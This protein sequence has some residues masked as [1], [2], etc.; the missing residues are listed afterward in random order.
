MDDHLRQ[1]VSPWVAEPDPILRAALGKLC[2]EAGELIAAASRCLIQ[3]LD[4]VEPETQRPNL[5]W[6]ENEV[7]D[8]TAAL[9]VVRERIVFDHTRI[10]ERT[11]LKA[12][13]FRRWH[14]QLIARTD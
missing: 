6:L 13:H 8:V 3:G 7:A 1:S 9:T 5:R 2:E 10:E 12:D 4:G 14:A 11:R